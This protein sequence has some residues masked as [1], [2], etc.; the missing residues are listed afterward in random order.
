[1]T[2]GAANDRP[3][4]WQDARVIDRTHHQGIEAHRSWENAHFALEPIVVDAIRL[5]VPWKCPSVC[6]V[7]Q[8]NRHS[9]RR[10]LSTGRCGGTGIF[11]HSRTRC[12]S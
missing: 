3:T 11:R 12:R 4:K 5:C 8:H 6:H 7:L 1:M 9:T 2:F 10:N